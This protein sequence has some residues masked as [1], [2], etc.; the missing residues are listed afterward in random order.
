M[1]PQAGRP[2]GSLRQ[3]SFTDNIRTIE[4]GKN[5]DLSPETTP[6]KALRIFATLVRD[7]EVGGSNPLAPTTF[8]FSSQYLTCQICT[9]LVRFFVYQAL[10]FAKRLHAT[11][12]SSLNSWPYGEKCTSL[13]VSFLGKLGTGLRF[14]EKNRRATSV[15][16]ASNHISQTP[17][18]GQLKAPDCITMSAPST[19]VDFG[20][21]MT[22]KAREEGAE[23]DDY[24]RGLPPERSVHRV[25][26]AQPAENPSSSG[27]DMATPSRARRRRSS[28]FVVEIGQF[29]LSND[30]VDRLRAEMAT[31]GKPEHQ[32]HVGKRDVRS[33]A[34]ADLQRG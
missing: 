23:H 1:L 16:V 31:R 20:L 6:D 3:L 27:T 29:R 24:R 25:C 30:A 18:C 22:K 2:V 32:S 17:V 15:F 26:R 11:N 33:S 4:R 7:Q 12:L 28:M 9:L 8:L 19:R 34:D 13:R 5:V 10:L 21:S 14:W